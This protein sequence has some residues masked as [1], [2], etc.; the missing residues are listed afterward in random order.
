MSPPGFDP[1]TATLSVPYTQYDIQAHNNVKLKISPVTGLEWPRV[2][3]EIKVP[4][5]G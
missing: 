3:Q 2:F 4:K 5:Y 1:R